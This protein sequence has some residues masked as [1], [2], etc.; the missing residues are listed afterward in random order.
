V[1]RS[2][3]INKK[4]NSSRN[5]IGGGVSPPASPTGNPVDSEKRSYS[6][7]AA[8]EDNRFK[9]LRPV[10]S[11]EGR[12]VVRV[13][14]NGAIVLGFNNS[15]REV[16]LSSPARE[17]D[18]IEYIQIE[19]TVI[20]EKGEEPG[21]DKESASLLDLAVFDN[22]DSTKPLYIGLD[23]VDKE[24]YDL[25][26]S[27]D[28]ENQDEPPLKADLQPK[29]SLKSPK[30]PKKPGMMASW[31]SRLVGS[32]SVSVKQAE[33]YASGKTSSPEPSDGDDD[34]LRVVSPSEFNQDGDARFSLHVEKKIYTNSHKKVA[35]R[36]RPLH[37]QVIISNLMLYIISVHE[38]V[39]MNRSGKRA[40]RGRRS[41]GGKKKR[42]SAVGAE[43]I[44]RKP[45]DLSRV[46]VAGR[47]PRA[48]AGRRS[49]DGGVVE[50][51]NALDFKGRKS[52]DGEPDN[53]AAI[54]D[55]LAVDLEEDDDETPLG[56]LVKR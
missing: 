24:D 22:V 51:M 33:K 53:S 34:L 42:R 6:E 52:V 41:P 35:D 23:A 17:G 43:P 7:V 8:F 11:R 44:E 38:D 18:S 40:K 9:S 31:L 36:S 3:V 30:D 26:K 12:Q 5:G 48:Q 55:L 27:L 1:R 54:A 20:I 56:M 10:K 45:S 47:A 19:Q 39:T 37:D 13:E 50:K 29:S 16:E 28:V 14:K 32:G 2:R 46:V 4:R 25:L 49:G 15:T 21:L